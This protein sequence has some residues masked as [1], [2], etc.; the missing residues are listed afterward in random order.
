VRHVD[1]LQRGAVSRSARTLRAASP[2]LGT[3]G[4]WTQRRSGLLISIEVLTQDD[5]ASVRKHAKRVSG[6]G[7]RDVTSG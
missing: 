1:M 5:S 3:R 6:T 7:G 2:L 4:Y